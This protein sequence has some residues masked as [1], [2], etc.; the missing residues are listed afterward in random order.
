MYGIKRV[1]SF[2]E[3]EYWKELPIRY[4]LDAMH[5]E[6]NISANVLKHLFGEKDSLGTRRDM[7]E[8]RVHPW[9][10][11]QRRGSTFVKPTAPYV[12]NSNETHEFLELMSS[13]RAPTGY[14][15]VFKKHVAR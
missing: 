8:V 14:A 13:I 7:E 5:V 15:I 2:F 4:T 11:L 9:L 12:F 6:R 1:P 3:L 10:W